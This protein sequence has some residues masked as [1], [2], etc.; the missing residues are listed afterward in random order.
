MPPTRSTQDV[1]LGV[2]LLI[3]FTR[4]LQIPPWIPTSKVGALCHGNYPGRTKQIRANVVVRDH[5]EAV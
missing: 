2:R 1:R 3:S 5:A 4:G